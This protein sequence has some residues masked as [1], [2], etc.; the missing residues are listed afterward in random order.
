MKLKIPKSELSKW[1]RDVKTSTNGRCALCGSSNGA[2]SH[3]IIRRGTIPH[4]GWLL[5]DNGIPLCFK[6]HYDGIHSMSIKVQKIFKVRIEQWLSR[7]GLSYS[8]LEAMCK[9]GS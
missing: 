8:I 1:S 5:V 7:K 6:C 2:E 3:H 9:T 4:K